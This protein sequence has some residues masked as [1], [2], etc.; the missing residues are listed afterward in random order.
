MFTK[1]KCKFAAKEFC[2]LFFF[3]EHNIIISFLIS[4]SFL[5]T[6]PYT[7]L[8]FFKL[9][10]SFSINYV[11]CISVCLYILVPKFHLLMPCNVAHMYIFSAVWHWASNGLL[12]PGEG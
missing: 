5:Q 3:F 9:L 7:P 12:F 4:F 11:S 6:L 1:D 2:L 8:F 10:A